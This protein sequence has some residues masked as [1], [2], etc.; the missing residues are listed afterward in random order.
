MTVRKLQLKAHIKLI[1]VKLQIF[2][3]MHISIENL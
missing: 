2:I 3:H 1:I